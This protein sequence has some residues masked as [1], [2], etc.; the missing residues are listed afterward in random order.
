MKQMMTKRMAVILLTSGLVTLT[1][2]KH[3]MDD[4]VRKPYS[5]TD[6]QRK[7]YAEQ[8]LGISIDPQQDWVLTQTLS[9][10]V[11]ADA[12]VEGVSRVAILDG[13]PFAEETSVLTMQ[14]ASK[15]QTVVLSFRAPTD[16]EVLYAAC[17]NSSGQ[18]LMTRPFLAGTDTEVSFTD[19]LESVAKAQTAK[20][21]SLN[22]QRRS[23]TTTTLDSSPFYTVD[24]SKIKAALQKVLPQGKDN[25]EAVKDFLSSVQ[26]R[27]NP[28]YV[29]D[30]PLAFFSGNSNA[31]EHL[32]YTWYPVG[33]E[34]YQESFLIEDHYD[35]NVDKPTKNL[36]T[37]KWKLNGHYL[38]CRQSDRTIDRQFTPGDRLTFQLTDGNQ[39]MDGDRVKVFSYNGYVFIACEDGNDWDYNDRVFWMP[40]GSERIEKPGIIPPQPEPTKP[41]LWTYAW[42]DNTMEEHDVCDYDM[43][44]CVIEVQEHADDP[45]K[46][47]ITLVALGATR[48][49]WLGFEN[50]QGK[51]YSDFKPVWNAELHA[52]M[53]ISTGTMVNT[54]NGTR[55][56]APITITIDKPADFDFQT[57]SFVLGAKVKENMR[58]IYEN[59]YYMLRISTTGTDPHGIIIPGRWQW[60]TERTCIKDAYAENGHAFNTW[61]SDRTQA[62]D[63]YRYPVTGKVISR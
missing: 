1:G 41:Q 15:G 4:Y 13:N 49:L 20:H 60:P 19:K 33:Q 57:N 31:N 9:V 12:D 51:S 37:K 42:E 18:A 47:D 63:W 34:D 54:G 61:A 24:Y 32:L 3:D 11:T 8:V 53:G 39:V 6:Q 48:D 62:K 30:L 5:V 38:L 50:K 7:S 56:I 10:E 44:D 2:C 25:R 28:Y 58:G 23:M 17:M 59:D 55:S 14:T 35:G 40:E 45:S 16:I 52:V 43:N 27:Q 46:L 22:A 36:A 29:Y 21:S 26:V